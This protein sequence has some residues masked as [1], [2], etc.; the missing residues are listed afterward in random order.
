MKI[1]H[2]IDSMDMGGAQSLL[3]ELLPI[4]K[5]F[6]SEV[7]VLEIKQAI[8]QTLTKKIEAFGI[9]VRS[10]SKKRSIRNPLNIF[11]LRKCLIDADIVHVHLFPANYWVAFAK[12]LGIVK[13]KIITT[14]HST[15]NKRRD[16][17]L[18]SKVDRLVYS[19]YSQ[20][21]ACGDK[22]LETFNA[23]FKSIQCI[24]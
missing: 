6:G 7:S 10:L 21:V 19:C 14:E 11:A 16:H 8:D 13:A 15:K 20:I 2:V 9:P 22:A 17:W 12:M 3:V 24:Y 5:E 4:Q 18:L 23:S 1:V